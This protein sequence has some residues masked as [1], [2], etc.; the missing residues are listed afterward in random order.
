MNLLE[1]VL[2][3]APRISLQCPRIEHHGAHHDRLQRGNPR[4]SPR[5]PRHAQ[6]PQT[7]PQP[8]LETSPKTQQEP[9]A[10][11]LRSS[12]CPA[13]PP[14][15]STKLRRQH[16]TTHDRRLKHT[17]S[18]PEPCASF[19]RSQQSCAGEEC[20]AVEWRWF[21]CAWRSAERHVHEHC[22]GAELK[23]E[24][25]VLRY[26]RSAGEVSRSEDWVVLLQCGDICGGE[27]SEYDAGTGVSG[28][29]GSKYGTEVRNGMTDSGKERE[30]TVHD[31]DLPGLRGTG[32]TSEAVQRMLYACETQMTSSKK[33]WTYGG[34]SSY[35]GTSSPLLA[36]DRQ[37]Q[38]GGRTRRRSE[39]RV[40][41]T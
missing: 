15:Y 39:R 2:V 41:K 8:K 16:T 38:A 18:Q 31:P 23:A 3:L 22:G 1:D 36:T 34:M 12:A 30:D 21:G 26:H 9:Q 4:R 40:G 32:A 7:L 28:C 35:G 17:I 11:P 24:E 29:E 27:G 25:E 10:H 33:T 20:E 37:A 6:D 14:K 13:I 5:L 19:P